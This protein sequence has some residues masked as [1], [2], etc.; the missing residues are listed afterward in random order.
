[1]ATYSGNSNVGGGY[2]LSTRSWNVEVVGEQGGT[3]PGPASAKYVGVPFPLLFVVVPVIGL[4][5]LMFL[6]FIGFALFGWAV[7]RR[8]T[9]HV[10]EGATELAATVAPDLATGAAY[11]TGEE[12]EA[13][14]A[15]KVTKEI[16]ALEKEIEGKRK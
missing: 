5:F 15:E 13:K 11:L 16:E 4:A 2:Y 7:A 6:P 8:I 14:P 1:M 9:G 10:A 12:G 3:L